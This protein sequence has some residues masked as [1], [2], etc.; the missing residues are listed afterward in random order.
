MLM[1]S[2]IVFEINEQFMLV[3]QIQQVLYKEDLK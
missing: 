3:S 2:E 1:N